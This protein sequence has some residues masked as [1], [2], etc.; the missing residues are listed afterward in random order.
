MDHA[1]ETLRHLGYRLTPQRRAVWEVVAA[2]SGH[3]SADEVFRAVEPRL[4]GID[5]STV[6]R[7]LELF[8]RHGLVA[9]TDMPGRTATFEADAQPHH[10]AVCTDCGTVRHLDDAAVEPFVATV[11]READVKVNQIVAFGT[12]SQ[13]PPDC[14]QWREAHA[15]RTGQRRG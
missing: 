2:S 12:C 3:L 13:G 8:W 11:S 9:K 4:P 7:C 1:L 15:S 6:Y 10:H 14:P 5:L